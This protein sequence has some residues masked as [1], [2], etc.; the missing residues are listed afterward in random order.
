MGGRSHRFVAGAVRVRN[1]IA[2]ST[3]YEETERGTSQHSGWRRSTCGDHSCKF[4]D[5]CARQKRHSGHQVPTTSAVLTRHIRPLLRRVRPWSWQAVTYAWAVVVFA[6]SS[7]VAARWVYVSPRDS[8]LIVSFVQ[9]NPCFFEASL[10][11][12]FNGSPLSAKP[13][14]APLAVDAE[15]EDTSLLG[16]VAWRWP[17]I[18]PT[19]P[20]PVLFEKC[21]V[22]LCLTLRFT[23]PQ[24]TL[25]PMCRTDSLPTRETRSTQTVL[26]RI[27]ARGCQAVQPMKRHH[28]KE[29]V[30]Y[31][32]PSSRLCQRGCAAQT[33]SSVQTANTANA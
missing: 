23:S 14:M 10:V 9:I 11:G 16:S 8:T 27:T 25:R 1:S 33:R 32:A 12:R 5:V 17:S 20:T 21:V 13:G 3:S 6:A 15:Y 24:R 31:G 26:I 2:P 30:R 22:S 19:N 4:N 7:S 28:R 18:S 29:E